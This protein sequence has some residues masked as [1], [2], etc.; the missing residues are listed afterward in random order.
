[1]RPATCSSGA[2]GPVT[3]AT[4]AQYR[5]LR[6]SYRPDPLNA[7]G[8]GPREIREFPRDADQRVWALFAESLAYF[9]DRAELQLAARHE[10]YEQAGSSTD[11]KIA[12]QFFATDRLSLRASWGTSFQAPSVFQ[13]GG[14]HEL[15]HA[16]RSLP[17]RRP[18][19]RAMYGSMPRAGS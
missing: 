15:A 6:Y 18:G 17:V 1:M 7:A 16:Y 2:A 4:G 14:Q 13:A 3:L 5:E 9:G 8:E 12:A 11:P 19:H 10:R